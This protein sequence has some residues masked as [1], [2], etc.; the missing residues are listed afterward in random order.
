MSVLVS[1]IQRMCLH[2]GPGIRTTVFLKGCNLRCPWCANPENI[3]MKIQ[4]YEV[5]GKK[6]KYG[7]EISKEE[8]KEQILKDRHFYSKEGGVTFSGGEPLLQIKQLEE[9]L[10]ELKQ[11]G[12]NLFVETA[13]FV[14]KVKLEIALQYI[15]GFIVDIKIL[16]EEKCKNVLGNDIKRYLENLEY[17]FQNKK[18]VIFR[19]PVIQPY[20]AEEKNVDKI[21]AL[22][23][24][25]KPNKVEIF[26]VHRLAEK[27]YK[28][29][30]KEMLE[31]VDI[32]DAFMIE[33]KNKIEELEIQTDICVI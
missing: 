23:K 31:F 14:D 33:L 27:K 26:K 24:R 25:Y 11:E 20:T 21:L 17:L 15:D 18:Q 9:L 19:I 10:I 30:G 28:S 6:G 8:L 1:N 13:L 12:I 5:D 22:L 2:D 4:E 29:L 32:S 16:E 3:L 7:Y